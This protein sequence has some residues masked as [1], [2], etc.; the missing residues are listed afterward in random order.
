MKKV[1]A[2]LLV[3]VMALSCVACGSK[4][5]SETDE[6]NGKAGEQTLKIWIGS[7]FISEAE[8]K[9]KQE[10]WF[11]SKVARQF[12]EANPGVKV[13]F[14]T[15]SDQSASHQTFKA[16]AA[17]DSGPDIA[18][19]WSGQSIFAMEDV[20]M[21][22]KDYIPAEDK[23]QLIGWETVTVGF[24]EG[25]AVLGYPVLGNEICGFIY[26]REIL[27]EAGLDFDNH[28]PKTLDEFM[29]ACE[30]IKAAGYLPIS[31]SDEG[32]G[33]GYFFGFASLWA[34]QEGSKR[35]ES[36]SRGVTKFADDEAFKESFRFANE[37]YSKG[38]LNE[39]Y[40]TSPDYKEV[41][42][43]GEAAMVLTGNYLV[44]TAGEALGMDNIGFCTLPDVSEDAMN[45]DTCIGGPG[46]CMVVSQKC[47]NPE[48]AVKFMSF[49]DSKENQISYLAGMSK[50]PLR[51]DISLEEAGMSDDLVYQQVAKMG[52][53]YTYWADNS[54]VPEVNAELQKLSALAITGKMDI[55]EMAEKLDQKAA[56]LA[57]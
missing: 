8:E 33:C 56:E 17:T 3:A 1:L 53:N 40:S 20:I 9:M 37:L 45:K 14:T 31:A 34:Q 32:W 41:F 16:A 46:Q 22:I 49:L 52:E 42:L 5:S 36:D 44:V 4:S 48:L 13:E 10:D 38:Y 11:I 51:K 39:D 57:Q 7:P 23:E 25:G 21:D 54:M 55:D 27:K 29:D 19:L 30:K 12:E 24:E 47:K 35:V 50:L 26:N 28:A 18:N 15:I 43:N 6:A 2:M